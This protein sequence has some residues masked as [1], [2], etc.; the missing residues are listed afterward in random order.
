MD[1]KSEI[2]HLSATQKELVIEAP[3]E[4]V[5]QEFDKTYSALGRSAK[6]AGF[7]PGRAPRSVIK[8]KFQR[9]A[10]D[11]VASQLL[12]QLIRTAL[13]EH[14]LHLVSDPN[15]NDLSLQEGQPLRLK[16]TVEVLPEVDVSNYKG[17]YVTKKVKAVTEADVDQALQRLRQQHAQLIPVEGRPAQLGDFATVTLSAAV[18]SPT[19]DSDSVLPQTQV[20]EIEMGGQEVLQ[21]F[22]RNLEGMQVGE[23]RQFRIDYPADYQAARLA[24]KQ[25]EYRATLEA[26]RLKELPDLDD[27][28]AK[29]IGED[30][31]TLA[32]YRQ[33]LRRRLEESNEEQAEAAL[34]Q[35]VLE[36]LV[37][38][39]PIEVPETLVRRRL[40]ARIRNLAQSAVMQ[41]ID[42]ESAEIDWQAVIGSEREKAV[43][44]IR[45]GLILQRI[46]ELEAISVSTAEVD[47][48]IAQIAAQRR[49][50][51]I[52]LRGRLT[53]EGALDT[54]KNEMRN[55]KA[56][57][58]VVKTSVVEREVVNGE[59]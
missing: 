22:N 3:A 4:M 40:E 55:R 15:I 38:A 56:L 13:D 28:L 12:P 37:E 17:G 19:P 46:A 29:T 45:A 49:E 33:E 6:V 25:V 14:H 24:G 9:E 10:R 2:T 47:A 32:D 34:G 41:G 11:A 21:E 52:Q 23:T 57:E 54:M 16:T 35:T 31:E 27:E 5:Q 39:H 58:L 1:V 30:F 51:A 43:Q 36:R 50:S 59:S 44:D 42:P 20:V 53:K 26:L 8:Q 7:R 48:E 18:V